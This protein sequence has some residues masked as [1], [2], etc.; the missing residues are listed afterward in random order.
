MCHQPVSSPLRVA[1]PP[2][3]I[4]GHWGMRGSLTQEGK[5]RLHPDTSFQLLLLHVSTEADPIAW[6]L[7]NFVVEGGG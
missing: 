6:G 7:G 5:Q 1:S 2:A 4:Q 3:G